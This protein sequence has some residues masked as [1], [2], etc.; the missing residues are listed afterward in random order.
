MRK[1][2][3]FLWGMYEFRRSWCRS[4]EDCQNT[5]DTGREWAHR[6]TSRYYDEEFYTTY[7]WLPWTKLPLTGKENL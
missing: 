3:A 1:I 2:Q 4:F 6:L 7:R 5:Y